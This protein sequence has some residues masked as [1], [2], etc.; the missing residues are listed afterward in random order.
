MKRKIE[1]RGKDTESDEWLYGDLQRNA[2]GLTAVISPSENIGESIYSNY[3][4]DENSIGQLVKEADGKKFY[5]GDI[6]V[7]KDTDEPLRVIL[8]WIEQNAMFA[9]LTVPEYLSYQRNG[10]IDM[11][12][13]LLWTYIFSDD[14]VR[15][16]KIIGNIFD[17]PELLNEEFK[18]AE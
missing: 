14:I 18:D 8:T 9:W 16:L 13:T 4:V 5:E 2:Y 12:S 6:A 10:K 7:T 17:N 3:E 11:D 15:E 1:F